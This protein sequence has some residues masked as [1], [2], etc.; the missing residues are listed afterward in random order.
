ML[1]GPRNPG[2]DRGNAPFAWFNIFCAV[3]YVVATVI[4]G[5]R[6]DWQ[7]VVWAGNAAVWS[8]VCLMMVRGNGYGS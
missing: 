7:A 2:R 1:M 5:H 6:C 3:S 4:G 8:S